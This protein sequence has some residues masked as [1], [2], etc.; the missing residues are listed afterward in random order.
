MAKIYISSTYKDLIDY[1]A[2]AI[3]TV[4]EMGHEP[5]CMEDYGASEQ[6]SV[7][8]CLSDVQRCDGYLGIVAWRYGFV[9]EDMGGRSIT[10]LEYDTAGRRGIE[11]MVLLQN[12]NADVKRAFIDVGEKG[13][14][15]TVFREKLKAKH[16]VA[17]FE[18]EKT[19]VA[20]VRRSIGEFDRK[21]RPPDD[22]GTENGDDR[23]GEIVPLLCNRDEQLTKFWSFFKEN[24]RGDYRK[25][26]FVFIHG[27]ENECPDSFLTRIVEKSLTDFA[28][29][30][31]EGSKVICKENEIE[32]PDSSNVET[33]KD[34][35]KQ[36]L[37]NHFLPGSTKDVTVGAQLCEVV[38][39]SK[40]P[41]VVV[42][43]TIS[44]TVWNRQSGRLLEWYIR[45]FWNSCDWSGELPL[46]L[47]FFKIL[48][49][50][51]G[52]GRKVFEFPWR[53]P[54]K[55]NI[56]EELRDLA[57]EL[58]DSCSLLLLDEL[59]P[60]NLEHVV[61]WMRRFR[62]YKNDVKRK[63]KA[64]NLLKKALCRD[65]NH[66][67]MCMA[68]DVLEKILAEQR[69]KKAEGILR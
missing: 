36:K 17:F 30:E 25:P 55:E 3:E 20:A 68:E 19:F 31:L 5:V 13:R 45:D 52:N 14:K 54:D 33:C 12:E 32:W 62:Y 67:R 7:F 50:D 44:S 47:V 1:R 46:F 60:V 21:M 6:P 28:E 24:I 69:S 38:D 9:P 53:K 26:Q 61:V 10:H 65:L 48:Y 37:L 15:V 4:K 18:D 11:R 34:C 59:A 64:E 66:I 29:Q 57:G 16:T 42:S 2:L 35:I 22:G 40:H 63:E 8:R 56:Q 41:M 58:E 43:H 49:C 23:Y 39:L 27:D 51:G